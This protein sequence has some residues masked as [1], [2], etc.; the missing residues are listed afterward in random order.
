VSFTKYRT[1][2]TCCE[3]SLFMALFIRVKGRQGW[4]GE[5]RR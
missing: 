5:P 4:K 1:P 3:A 2:P